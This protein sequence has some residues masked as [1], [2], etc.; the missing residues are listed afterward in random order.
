VTRAAKAYWQRQ[1]R[2][3]L[4]ATAMDHLN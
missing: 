3:S 2:K 1:P 4:S